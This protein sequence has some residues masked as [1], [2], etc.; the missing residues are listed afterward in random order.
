M[1]VLL[2]FGAV[3][4]LGGGLLF[5]ALRSDSPRGR[6]GRGPRPAAEPSAPRTEDPPPLA[7][8]APTPQS[9]P[10]AAA[11]E[12]QSVQGESAPR[13]RSLY[14]GALIADGSPLPGASL[15][16]LRDDQVLAETSSDE[17]GRFLL[18]TE[19]TPGAILRVVARGYVQLE[20][21]LVLRPSGGSEKLGNLRLVRGR[22]IAGQVMDGS[23]RP[24]PDA[25]IRATP[26]NSGT[27]VLVSTGRSGPDGRFELPDAPPGTAVVRVRAKGFGE[28]EVQKP[29]GP[30]PL[31]IQLEPGLDLRIR[32]VTPRGL[33]V[34]EAEVTI[35]AQGDSRGLKRVAKSDAQGRVAFEGLGTPTWAV[36]ATHEEYRPA[37]RPM[38]A[39]GQ[40]ESLECIPWPAIEG[41]VRVSGGKAPPPGTRVHA[42][43][44]SAPSDRVGA[45]VGG[46]E[47]AA[48]GHF[49]LPGLRAGDWRIRAVAP[50]Y[51]PST[52][53]P[54]RLG[55]EGD[56]FAGT[57]LLE[58]G[59]SL[60]FEI[61]VDGKPAPGAQIET[62]PTAPTPA[63]RWALA[64]NRSPS[65]VIG[66]PDGRIVL[67]NLPPGAF[68]VVAL[69]EGC[70]PV[71]SGPHEGSRERAPAPIVI[72]LER[73]ARLQ[74]TVKDPKGTPMGGATLRIVE[75]AGV[76][77]FPITVACGADGRYTSAWLPAGH[78]TIDAFAPSEPSRRSGTEEVELAP[79]DQRTLDLEL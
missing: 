79:G 40:E 25:E 75:K 30:E 59:G 35:T 12:R 32:L 37:G 2:L 15:Q 8:P 22:R 18:E 61:R 67:E 21:T 70:M 64:N 29:A 43:P 3:L 26:Q 48:D 65:R 76:L 38:R 39:T 60:V 28:R 49:R 31:V 44:A 20:R 1:K 27:D 24:I 62:L 7:A 42:L 55:I 36:R 13:P 72:E 41:D 16:I 19:P 68:W 77:G 73:G 9:T 54:V 5:V 46:K 33:P 71:G 58:A 23:G 6:G 66:G 45:L 17:R 63:Q 56:A 51:A 4:L 14:E 47:V 34:P 57:L 78:Y 50:G 52:S 69:A 74:G 11:P 10:R 53:A